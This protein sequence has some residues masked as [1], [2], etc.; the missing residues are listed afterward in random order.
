MPF[1]PSYDWDEI[2][3]GFQPP[4]SPL[5]Q[6]QLLRQMCTFHFGVPVRVRTAELAALIDP[7]GFDPG[8]I[9]GTTDSP[10]NIAFGVHTRMLVAGTNFGPFLNMVVVAGNCV[11]RQNGRTENLLLGSFISDT[12]ARNAFN[13]LNGANT[14]V[15]PGPY[16][17]SIDESA[18]TFKIQVRVELTPA[19]KVRASLEVNLANMASRFTAQPQPT[20]IPPP[21]PLRSTDGLAAKLARWT[22]VQGDGISG[23][24][25]VLN[26]TLVVQPAKTLQLPIGALRV[27][28]LNDVLPA[29]VAIRNNVEI[30]SANA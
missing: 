13:T 9:Q 28:G 26:P 30:V 10:V 23:R 21:A 24:V 14:S 11:N 12:N 15:A 16:T 3:P 4:T 5:M 17:V 18:A 7:L 8:V 29:Q 27:E 1:P 22:A 2:A 25:S 19:C 6:P 20:A